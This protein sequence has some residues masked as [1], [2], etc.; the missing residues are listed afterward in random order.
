MNYFGYAGN[1]LEVDLTR[2]QTVKKPLDLDLAKAFIGGYGLNCRLAYDRFEADLPPFDPRN[3]LIIGAG[4]LVGTLAPGS[5]QIQGTVK[6]PLPP[7]PD[8]QKYYI[9]SGSSGSRLF[10]PMLK[11]AG[12]DH[13]IITGRAEKPVYLKFIDDDVEICDAGDLWGKRDTYETNAFLQAKYGRSGTIVIG[14][15]GENLVRFALALTD[16]RSTLG[17]NGLGAI[18]GSKNLKAIVVKGSRGIDIAEPRRFSKVVEAIR[19]AALKNS[20]FEPFHRLGI[21]CAWNGWKINLNV[22]KW[23]QDEWDKAYGIQKAE[24]AIKDI[25]ACNACILG[26]RISCEITEGDFSGQGTQTCQFLHMAALGQSFNTRDWGMVA[27]LMDEC[28]RAG[29]CMLAFG[30]IASFLATLFEQGTLT[31]AHLDGLILHRDYTSLKSLA[32]RIIHRKGFGNAIANGWFAAR[33]KF[34]VD[35]EKALGLIKGAFPAYDARVV[36]IDPRIFQLL[37]NPRGAHHPQTHW[38][39]SWPMQPLDKIK[40]RAKKLAITMEEYERIFAGGSYN[41]G[42]LTRHLQDLGMTVDSLGMCIFYPLFD[43]EVHM[44]HLSELYSAA[45]GIDLRPSDLKRAG[46][47]AFTMLKILNMREGFTR[48][49]DR[50]PALWFRPKKTAE[51]V[52]EI[53]DYYRTR[54]LSKEDIENLLDDYYEERG[55]DLKTGLPAKE[56]LEALGLGNLQ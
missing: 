2:G 14:A 8:G 48:E 51:G 9:G 23:P 37:V 16:N 39:T 6:F 20:Y 18:M 13:L 27:R 44:E 47:R 55:W 36:K 56:K 46:E 45:T 50:P 3:P 42:R 19:Q 5:G 34:G 35:F 43:F 32:E 26:C 30:A 38:I 11:Y 12:Y 1:V 33:E 52:E 28:N 7:S 53:M 29:M 41:A 10:G 22:G 49:D 24:E 4:P 25:H 54:K 31:P 17:R 40:D 15:A 21:H